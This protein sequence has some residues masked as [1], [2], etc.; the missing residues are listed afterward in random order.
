MPSDRKQ[1]KTKSRRRWDE[2]R[3][4]EENLMR[5]RFFSVYF[6]TRIFSH[7]SAPFKSRVKLVDVSKDTQQPADRWMT[8][9][10]G[11]L[12]EKSLLANNTRLP[13]RKSESITESFNL[14]FGLP[15]AWGHGR[16]AAERAG[17]W[18]VEISF[19]RVF[20]KSVGIAGLI[21]ECLFS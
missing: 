19:R 16:Q 2:K 3:K 20:L 7:L 1:K 12:T 6:K 10:R 9:W 18:E 11:G 13:V 14:A 17:R 21:L 5:G 8:R 15:I 4:Y